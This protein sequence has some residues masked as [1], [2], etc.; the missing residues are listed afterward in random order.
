MNNHSAVD[1]TCGLCIGTFG[2][3]YILDCH[4]PI[5]LE[6]VLI[7]S[8]IF[9]SMTSVVRPPTNFSEGMVTG[10]LSTTTIALLHFFTKLKN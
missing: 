3:L 7:G 8:F 5:N 9:S 10:I 2:T 4:P 1:I 6:K